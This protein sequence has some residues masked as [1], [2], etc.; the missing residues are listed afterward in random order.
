[1][2]FLPIWRG[3]SSLYAEEPQEWLGAHISNAEN[4]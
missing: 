1:M 3:T 4:V 2:V